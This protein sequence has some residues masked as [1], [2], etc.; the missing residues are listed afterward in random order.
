[1]DRV[2]TPLFKVHMPEEVFP[3]V[4]RTLA[5]GA[6]APGAEVPRFE[7]AVGA[8]TGNLRTV[9]VSDISGALT[10]A[11]HASGVGP[12][13]EVVVSPLSCLA[14]TMP[15]ANLSAKPVWCDVDPETGMPTAAMMRA[16]ITG[17]TRAL[18][19]YHWSGDV[20]DL[21]GVLALA[22]EC[23]LPLIEDASEA[24]GAEFHGR[25]LGHHGADFTAYS[26]GPVRHIT[27]GDG[28]ALCPGPGVDRERLRR[29]RRY[30]IDSATFRLPNGDLN[31]A[32]DIVEAGFNF[33][34]S[35][36]AAS[37]GLAQW[38]WAE[39]NVH[40]HRDNG[41][42]YDQALRGVPGLRLLARRT[43]A[44]S[45]YWTYSLRA[46]R[47]EDLV[48]KLREH[49]IGAQRLHLRNDQYACFAAQ[50]A[51]GLHGV[52]ALDAENLS[53]PCGWWVSAAERAR[54]AE[55]IRS[56]W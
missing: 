4:Q 27:C 5:S 14:T 49:G 3:A 26:F 56:G 54:I 10:L 34:L 50:A 16:K 42:G 52:D 40:A 8:F 48:R 43:D 55:T 32:S 15:I 11:L 44:V 33:G 9:A 20:G 1:M 46:E 38:H 7:E 45:A 53:I 12:G 31:P 22:R 37:I 21:D 41:R 13:D 23:S 2:A 17:R 25:R 24:F 36:V 28:A 39:R 47:R 6:I 19:L 51:P 35:N 29:L 18:L 30:G